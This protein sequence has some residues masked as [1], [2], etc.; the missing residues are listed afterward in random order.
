MWNIDNKA[1]GLLIKWVN[2]YYLKKGNTWECQITPKSC[3]YWMRILNIRDTMA[4]GLNISTDKRTSVQS[5][6]ITLG[7]E[8]LRQKKP[9]VPWY[10]IIL[11]KERIP[12]CSLIALLLL[13]EKRLTRTCMN[14][15]AYI[16]S[17]YEHYATMKKEIQKHPFFRC[18]YTRHISKHV[19][20][21]IFAHST[22]GWWT[23]WLGS[24]SVQVTRE[25]KRLFTT[26]TVI[27]HECWPKKRKK[28]SLTVGFYGPKSRVS[29]RGAHAAQTRTFKD[30]EL[31]TEQIEKQHGGAVPRG[32]VVPPANFCLLVLAAR[33]WRWR[34]FLCG[35]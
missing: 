17:N 28:K 34:C 5:Y 12:K 30:E 9:F 18:L 8:W 25:K 35:G 13:Q 31:K 1:N 32:T 3:C 14:L 2:H 33:V 19:I 23:W 10:K 21:N 27:A 16:M 4:S 20:D 6:T 22:T 29:A 15:L 24:N 11:H 7:Y 26:F